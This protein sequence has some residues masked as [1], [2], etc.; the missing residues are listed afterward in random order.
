MGQAEPR[1]RN[2]YSTLLQMGKE[3]GVGAQGVI[4]WGYPLQISELD[5]A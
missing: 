1:V 2:I 4:S 5:I 3:G